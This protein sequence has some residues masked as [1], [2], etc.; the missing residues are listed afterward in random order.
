MTTEQISQDTLAGM[1]DDELL[2]MT[3]EQIQSTEEVVETEGTTEVA[4][5]PETTE[6]AEGASEVVEETATETTDEKD[7][8]AFY[9]AVTA[10]FKANGTNL[11]V[12]D[13]NQ[14]ISMMQMGANYNK[15]MQG[16][17]QQRADLLDEGKLAF[18]IDL[19]K[20]SPEAIAKFV[21]ESGVDV[22]DIDSEEKAK[23]YTPTTT[24]PTAAALDLEDTLSEMQ[25]TPTYQRTMS[26]MLDTF[27]ADSRA[28]LV[29]KPSMILELN[30]HVATG[31]YD[32]IQ[33]ILT[34][35]RAMGNFN[36]QTDLD[37]YMAIGGHLYQQGT[38]VGMSKPAVIK[39]KVKDEALDKQRKSAGG[40]P[41]TTPSTPS[42]H[43]VLSMS[44]EEF[45]KLKL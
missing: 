39:P 20:K 32:Q 44:D 37:A 41:T 27:D 8:K 33:G 1:S 34:R 45:A 4:N 5:E 29:A 17:K 6:V 9:D 36:G 23:N 14:I 16:M 25:A 31:A 2:N 30:S 28:A 43:N 26:V 7:Y 38:L 12:E 22:Y 42:L 19:H 13:P 24:A 18:L 21:R 15:K 11:K 40:S 35:E 3:P 10:E